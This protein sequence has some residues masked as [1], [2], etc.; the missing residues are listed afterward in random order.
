MSSFTTILTV[1]EADASKYPSSPAYKIPQIDPSTGRVEAWKTITYGEFQQDI[2]QF[3]K[4]WSLKLNALD[5]PPR[6]VIGVWYVGR[7]I[8]LSFQ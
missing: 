5:I 7:S 4:Y 1:I 6:S 3:A 8:G 2:E